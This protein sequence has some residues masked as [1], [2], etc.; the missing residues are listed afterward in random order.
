MTI[1]RVVSADLEE[2][3][4]VISDLMRLYFPGLSIRKDSN[5]LY[6]NEEQNEEQ[7]E[8]KEGTLYVET[9][10]DPLEV[11]VNLNLAGQAYS[12][13]EG[14]Q[15]ETFIEEKKNRVRRLLRLALHKLLERVLSEDLSPWGILTGVRPTK[16]VHRF[17]D[18]GLTKERIMHHLTRDYGISPERA[19][20]LWKVANFQHPILPKKQDTAKLVSLYIGI[21]F[22]PTRCYYCSFPSFSLKQWGYLLD[23]YLSGLGRELKTVGKLLVDRQVKVQ[24]V[25]IGG[26][27]PTILSEAQLATLLEIITAS[28]RF[29]ENREL[30]VEGGRPDTLNGQKLQVLKD[31]AVTR[32]SINP[33]TMQ[34]ETLV[35]I[36]RKHSVQEI[37]DAYELAREI[38]IPIINMDLI[39]GLPGEDCTILGNTLAEVLKLGPEN[40]TLHALAL[41]RAAYYRQEKINLPLPAEGQA[42]MDLAHNYL[43]EA[44]YFPYYLYR[45]RD[46]FA[47]GENVGYS[48]ADKACLYNIQMI[49]ER[50]TILGFGV[51]SGSKIVNKA[52]WTLENIYNPKDII[53]YLQRLEK[54]IE[55]K[56][57]KLQAI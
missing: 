41:K 35:A 22:C 46:I 56:V 36:G 20:L 33:Q 5:E 25:Y 16:I 19:S 54:I 49:E 51:G 37:I 57:D 44:G 24:T 11:K 8:I 14:L 4:R 32:L 23:D 43:R 50:Q 30:T 40:I 29:V 48:I 13:T 28:F 18:E 26:G 34:D 21:P 7:N 3:I 31:Y 10:D 17:F 52:D 42:M 53:F 39:I 55:K 47:H 2:D 6:I 15:D 12:Q 1:I 27:T 38:G 45:Q 9:K